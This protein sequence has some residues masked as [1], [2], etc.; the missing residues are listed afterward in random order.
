MSAPRIL[1]FGLN[2][3]G[4]TQALRDEMQRAGYLVSYVDLQPRRVLAKALRTL[5]PGVYAKVQ[6][7]HLDR[8][9]AAAARQTFARVIF[10]QAHQITTDQLGR[11]RHQHRQTPFILYNWDSLTTQDYRP[12]AR[13][14]DRVLTFDAKDAADH[15]FEYLPLFATRFIQDLRQDRADAK[16]VA[17]IG[18]IVTTR[19]YRAVQDFRAYCQ[20]NGINFR[21][22]L[23]ISPVV[24]ARLL[25]QGIVPRGVHFID[26]TQENMTDLLESASAMF[27]FANHEQTG[28]TMRTME[29]LCAGKKI[30]TN[31]AD[32]QN[33][34]FYTKDRVHVFAGADFGD[35]TGF[36]R[37]PLADPD[38]RFSD[39]HIQRFVQHLLGAA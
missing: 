39:H 29:S 19:R 24:W 16:T 32:I 10:L 28:L 13:Y 38:A 2:Y 33:A 3:H 26:I 1:F 36:L 21:S 8:A 30:V 5:L 4:Y 9:I 7:A 15:G 6:H 37:R 23:K 22:Y 31:N 12:Q 25:R 18:N 27:D 11:L 35:V 34:T 17:M 20:I 14:F